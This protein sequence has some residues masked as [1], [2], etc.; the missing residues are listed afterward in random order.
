M[1]ITK[2]SEDEN[3]QKCGEKF[4]KCPRVTLPPYEYDFICVS[5]GYN[6]VEWKNESTE[7]QWK[8][9]FHQ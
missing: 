7:I 3:I 9:N 2:F 4:K 6:I 5:S 1:E 8:E